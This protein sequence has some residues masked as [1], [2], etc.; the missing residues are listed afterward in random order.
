M[1]FDGRHLYLMH[2][3]SP[4]ST[5]GYVP[6]G[7]A[8]PP[9]KY[10]TVDRLLRSNGIIA[11]VIASLIFLTVYSWVDSFNQLYREIVTGT[12]PDPPIHHLRPTEDFIPN[13]SAKWKFIYAILLTIAT[14]LITYFLLYVWQHYD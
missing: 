11:V 12:K 10:W 8:S 14:V 13:L 6:L 3:T 9:G 4:V 1:S 7:H 5:F 2:S